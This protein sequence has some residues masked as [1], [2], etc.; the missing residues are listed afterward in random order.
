MA[1]PGVEYLAKL[2]CACGYSVTVEA[3]P[4]TRYDDAEIE[5]DMPDGWLGCYDGKPPECPACVEKRFA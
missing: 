4:V 5:H 2:T 3:Y 1:Q